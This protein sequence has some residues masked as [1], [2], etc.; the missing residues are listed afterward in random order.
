MSEPLSPNEFDALLE[1]IAHNNEDIVDVLVQLQEK[2]NLLARD[3][4]ARCAA[5]EARVEFLE[6]MLV[7]GNPNLEENQ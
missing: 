3:A 1:V 6:N 2:H 5:L 7:I 4:M